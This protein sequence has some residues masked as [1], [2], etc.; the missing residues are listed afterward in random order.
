MRYCC[1]LELIPFPRLTMK[2]LK[3]VRLIIGYFRF[4]ARI[5][6]VLLILT[7]AQGW[8]LEDKIVFVSKRNFTPEVFLVEGLNGRPIQLTRNMFA[9]WP[10]ISPDGTEVV[11][12][13]R[14]PG[15]ISNIF[16]LR[17]ATHAI[18]RANRGRHATGKQ[19]L[20]D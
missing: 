4:T 18:N 7:P 19:A 13:S 3:F 6:Q 5:V 14:P 20:F 15:G 1:S 2:S 10:S 11:F 16:K 9:S 17:I 12:V 8:G